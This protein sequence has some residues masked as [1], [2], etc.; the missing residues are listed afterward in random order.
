MALVGHSVGCMVA[1]HA[2]LRLGD[3]VWALALCGGA[4]E[5]R[6]QADAVFEE[7]VRLARTG[8]MDEIAHT[9]ATTGLSE[10]ARAE[11]PVLHGLMLDQ[12]A[13]N[14]P[15]AYA[16]S[17]QATR[18]GSMHDLE[19][20]S[21]P[22]LAFCGSEDPVAPARLCG[23]DRRRG[24]RRGDRRDRECSA[25]VHARAPRGGEQRPVRVPGSGSRLRLALAKRASQQ[26]SQAWL[27]SQPA[28][29]SAISSGLERP[30]ERLSAPK[31]FTIP[32]PRA[33]SH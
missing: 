2:A 12:I 29:Q 11:N 9:V 33:T 26:R 4:I 27:S 18:E 8:R 28:L 3:R 15:G 22:A 24:A 19:R 32:H 13:S 14:D 10:R 6:P 5:W 23:R 7:R 21:C 16:A 30:S 31:T 1:E 20:V 25:L 17:S